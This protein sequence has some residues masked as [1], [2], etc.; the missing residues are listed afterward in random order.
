MTLP[1]AMLPPDSC[2]GQPG[3]TP[4]ATVSTCVFW[5]GTT[6]LIAFADARGVVVAS[7]DAEGNTLQEEVVLT[8]TV[9]AVYSSFATADQKVL[10]LLYS[11]SLSAPA[12]Y[13][14]LDL[15]GTL[16]E[17]AQALAAEEEGETLDGTVVGKE[18]GFL[19][20][21]GYTIPQSIGGVLLYDIAIDG[22]LRKGVLISGGRYV[23]NLASLAPSAHGGHLLVAHYDTGG[24]FGGTY[25]LLY[26]IDDALQPVYRQDT[27]LRSG[28]LP[29]PR[30]VLDDPER[31]LVILWQESREPNDP[32]LVQEYGCLE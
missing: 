3:V 16:L 13:A 31:D 20:A 10:L 14:V 6:Y 21:L 5:T 25:S 12:F 29:S 28:G 2:N 8:E 9:S 22:S 27:Q 30:A 23:H 15:Q 1:D 24:Q 18:D 26:L 17:P 11:A 32:L 7:L 4:P 19:V